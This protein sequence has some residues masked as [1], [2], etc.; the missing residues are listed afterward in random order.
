MKLL[1]LCLPLL[2]LA[3]CATTPAAPP[4]ASAAKRA[5]PP[6]TGIERII[7]SAAAGVTALLGPPSLDR[8]EGPAR[9]LQFIRSPC[10]LDVFLYPNKAGAPVVTTA[11]ARKADGS[12]IEAG[13]CLTLIVPPRQ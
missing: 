3:A 11:V 8:T 10:V 5:P 13:A 2:A 1:L 7:G 9:L 12:R 4:V 6:P